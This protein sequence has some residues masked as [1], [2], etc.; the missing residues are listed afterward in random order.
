MSPSNAQGGKISKKTAIFCKWLR[1]I[2]YEAFFKFIF[3]YM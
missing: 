2:K 3:S 1:L